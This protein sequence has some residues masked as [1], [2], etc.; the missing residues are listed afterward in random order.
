MQVKD[1]IVKNSRKVPRIIK[2]LYIC[3]DLILNVY[4]K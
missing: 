4:I 3:H 2:K 1:N